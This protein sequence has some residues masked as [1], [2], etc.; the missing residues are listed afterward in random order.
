MFS[1][2]IN[3]VTN[4]PK[5]RISPENQSLNRTQGNNPNHFSKP[6]NGP[7][8]T[9]VDLAN[10]T[11]NSAAPPQLPAT[12]AVP[13]SVNQSQI[14]PLTGIQFNVTDFKPSKTSRQLCE[15]NGIR[16][17]RHLFQKP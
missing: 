4:L 15:E 3:L 11:T 17:G 2:K 13:P 9:L 12:P 7:A 10:G 8:P 5:G 14:Q 6:N 1:C 16:F